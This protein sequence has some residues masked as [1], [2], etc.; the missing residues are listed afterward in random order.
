MVPNNNEY[1]ALIIRKALEQNDIYFGAHYCQDN[2]IFNYHDL[3]YSYE[4]I[5]TNSNF[6]DD[7]FPEDREVFGI[8]FKTNKPFIF[9]YSI[10]DAIDRDLFEKYNYNETRKVL[11]DL[12]I[13]EITDKTN[14]D[15]IIKIKFK[16]NYRNSSTR[17]II[18]IAPKNNE[19]TLDTFK[20]A[21][22]VVGLLN[23]KPQGVKT[24]AVYDVGENE[25]IDAEIDITDILN[26]KNEYIMSIISQELRFE[27][28]N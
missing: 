16:A 17:Y 23:Q 7:Y 14:N 28:K 4:S 9:T 25:L 3:D 15:N 26:D 24:G 27:K 8:E 12:K 6:T 11:N 19:N 1:N 18:L 2:T 20:D 5:Y 22:H 13:N 10:Q 21:C